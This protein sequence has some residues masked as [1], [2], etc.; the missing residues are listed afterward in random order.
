M[1]DSPEYGIIKC[2]FCKKEMYCQK[3]LE[4]HQQYYCKKLFPKKHKNHES[5]KK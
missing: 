2:F 1:D 5:K 3:G 4:I